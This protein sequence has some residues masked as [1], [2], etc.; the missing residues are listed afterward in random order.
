MIYRRLQL[1]ALGALCSVVAGC[2]AA[3]PKKTAVWQMYDIPAPVPT[4]QNPYARP[5]MPVDNDSYYQAPR[6]YNCNTIGDDP[7]CGGG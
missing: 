7:S 3:A 2:S 6:G 4:S 1:I 5:A